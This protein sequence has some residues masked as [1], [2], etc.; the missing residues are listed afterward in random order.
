MQYP[1]ARLA[2][3]VGGLLLSGSALA[4]PLTWTNENGAVHFQGMLRLSVNQDECD[5]GCLGPWRTVD[6]SERLVDGDSETYWTSNFSTAEIRGHQRIGDGLTAIFRS[7]WNVNLHDA[8]QDRFTA[9]EQWLG[10]K[11][12]WGRVKAGRVMTPY[13]TSGNR[14][15]PFRR[16]GLDTRFF[17]DIQSALHHG[18]GLGHGRSDEALRYDSPALLPGLRAQA[19]AAGDEDPAFGGG[20]VYKRDRLYGFAQFY[21]NGESGDDAA[22]KIGGKFTFGPTAIQGQYEWDAGLISLNEGIGT[23]GKA[24]KKEDI[25][26]GG[27]DL[28]GADTWYLG[29]SQRVSPRLLVMG[30]YGQRADND[31]GENGHDGWMLGGRYRFGQGLSGYAG[32]MQKDLNADAQDD[33]RRFTLGMTYKF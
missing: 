18:I 14:M 27:N 31:A 21:D 10:I 20:L 16:G 22:Y 2:A 11:G 8:E 15:N 12:E 4:E 29:V 1:T 32:Y 13:M 19:F 33:D 25:V 26:D 30:Q 23:L 5:S 9:F 24:A 7:E 3:A 28:T 17:T 6:P